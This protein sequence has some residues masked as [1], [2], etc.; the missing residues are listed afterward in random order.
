MDRLPT[1]K[2]FFKDVYK[3]LN[4]GGLLIT[5]SPYFFSFSIMYLLVFDRQTRRVVF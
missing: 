3:R 1:P 4:P 5:S 2:T